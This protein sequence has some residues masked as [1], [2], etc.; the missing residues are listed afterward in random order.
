MKKAPPQAGPSSCG[1]SIV[2]HFSRIARFTFQPVAK[3]VESWYN[4]CGSFPGKGV[5]ALDILLDFFVSVGASI[6]GNYVSKWLSR[7]RKDP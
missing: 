5:N 1:N 4:H 6:V 7:H 2:P 3:A